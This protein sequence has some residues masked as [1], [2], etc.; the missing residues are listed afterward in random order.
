MFFI[1]IFKTLLKMASLSLSLSLCLYLCLSLSLSYTH[2]PTSKKDNHHLLAILFG[3]LATA[4][5]HLNSA[6]NRNVKFC[7]LTTSWELHVL[8]GCAFTDSRIYR[9]KFW[10]VLYLSLPS[11]SHSSSFSAC[12]SVHLSFFPL[13]SVPWSPD[14]KWNIR[15]VKRISLFKC[16]EMMG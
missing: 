1:E 14:R 8:L 6:Y 11:L 15:F 16:L 9:S 12:I 2:A 5:L 13:I 7:L 3:L 4:Y 10:S